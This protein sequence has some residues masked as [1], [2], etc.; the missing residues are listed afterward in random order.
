ML[1]EGTVRSGSESEASD[2]VWLHDDNIVIAR[3]PA[4]SA[5]IP[6]MLRRRCCYHGVAELR[7]ARTTVTAMDVPRSVLSR[8]LLPASIAIYTT[9]ALAAFEG[10]SVAAALPQV[11]ADLGR[12]DLLPWVITGYLF[13]SGVATVM[14]GSLV[15]RFGTHAIFGVAVVVFTLAGTLA[16]LT[17]S[18]P[19]LVG[20]R[21]VQGAASGMVFAAALTAVSLIYPDHLVGRAYAANSTV[22]GVMG[23]AAPAIAALLITTLSWRWIFF[24]N[25]PLGAIAWV[26]GRRVMPGP[27][28]DAEAAPIDLRGTVLLAV[29]TLAT[30]VAVDRIGPAS[31]L[32]LIAAGSLA[33]LYRRHARSIPRPVLRP[34]HIVHQPYGPIGLTVTM[35]I[36]GGFAA[37]IYLTLYVSAGRGAGPTLTA[38]SVF[39]FVIG[40]TGG[41][42]LSSR[43]LDR[44]AETTVMRAGLFTTVPG[45]GLAAAGTW[46]NL[47]L[48]FLFAGLLLAAAGIGLATNAA[49]TLLRSLTPASTIGRVTSA[50]Q[51]LRNQGFTIGSA[52]GGAVL[53]LVVGASLGS[54][55]PV[56]ELLA[57]TAIAGDDT[58]AQAVRSGYGWAVTCGLVLAGLAGVPL[59]SLRNH[60]APAREAKRAFRM[61]EETGA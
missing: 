2:V 10:T 23:A 57:G 1:D 35:M 60:L 54:V 9:V 17:S 37:N 27:L 3:R 53:L 28:P 39:F 29:F 33:W 42:N 59:R 43:M 61:T 5:R 46:L 36:T 8:P 25:L 34:E 24:I 12:L 14:A 18:M 22:W 41:A 51:F 31:A 21:L 50:H 56:R 32:W 48:A 45:L 16:G 44:L 19:L 15:D 55:E 7:L 47:H 40:W 52:L 49:L 4:A 30:V 26:L 58:V 20:V 38:W 6:P 11:V 13:A